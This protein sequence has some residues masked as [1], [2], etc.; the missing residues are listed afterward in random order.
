M[1]PTIW[2][3]RLLTNDPA[4][5]Q[6]M[7]YLVKGKS[8][9]LKKT[10]WHPVHSMGSVSFP[11]ATVQWEK[12]ET[13]SCCVKLSSGCERETAE[14]VRLLSTILVSMAC[15]FCSMYNVFPSLLLA[16][17]T[18][19]GQLLLMLWNCKAPN[20][21]FVLKCRESSGGTNPIVNRNSWASVVGYFWNKNFRQDYL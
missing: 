1:L 2:I 19:L 8:G 11:E 13:A 20:F 3:F 18:G 12:M 17:H 16:L 15:S 10:G 4:A 14:C 6:K 21:L 9:T 7:V 5:L